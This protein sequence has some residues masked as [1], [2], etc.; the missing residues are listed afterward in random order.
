MPVNNRLEEVITVPE[1]VKVDMKKRELSISG[2]NG[3]VS[4][5]FKDRRIKIA[6]DGDALVISTELPTKREH[7]LFGTYRSHVNNMLKGAQEDFVYKLKI[8]YS[9]FP[10][11]VRV[12]KDRMVIENF[13]GESKPRKAKIFGKAKV[14]IQGDIVTVSANNI[15]DAG[16]TAANIEA[17]TKIKKVDPRVFQDGIYLIEKDGKPLR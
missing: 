14:D 13:I 4:K 16:Q 1:G 10:V 5:V 15:E 6:I 3:E 9:H 17:A 12:E 7:A 2:P 8:I 11:K